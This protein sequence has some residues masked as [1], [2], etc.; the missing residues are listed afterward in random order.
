YPGANIRQ[1]DELDSVIENPIS[2]VP[3]LIRD[4][5]QHAFESMSRTRRSSGLSRNVLRASLNFCDCCGDLVHVFFIAEQ[6]RLRNPNGFPRRPLSVRKFLPQ[7]RVIFCGLS[8]RE[9][10]A[11][12]ATATHI[13]LVQR[14]MTR[15][16]RNAFRVPAGYDLF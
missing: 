5:L 10:L 15:L 4:L 7:E 3:L 1:D 12:L 16:V 6:R 8:S 14:R 11:I 2:V 13:Q 9:T